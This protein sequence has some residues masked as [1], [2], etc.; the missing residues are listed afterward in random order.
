MRKLPSPG[1]WPA[2]VQASYQAQQYEALKTVVER[3]CYTDEEFQNL[4]SMVPDG[5][6]AERLGTLG[7][8]AEQVIPEPV[9]EFNHRLCDSLNHGRPHRCRVGRRHEARR[10]AQEGRR[11][12]APDQSSP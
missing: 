12:H 3:A 7:K 10:G 2:E 1:P 4:M 6:V 9:V 8:L 11:E 5:P